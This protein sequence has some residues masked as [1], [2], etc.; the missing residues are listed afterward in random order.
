MN[1]IFLKTPL[2]QEK[3]ALLQVMQRVAR[4]LDLRYFVVGA[5]ARDILMYHFHGFPVNRASPDIDFALA[6]ESWDAFETVRDAL[7]QEQ[8]FGVDAKISQRLHYSP[9]AADGFPI[10]MIPFGGVEISPLAVAWPPDMKIVMNVAGYAEALDSVIEVSV[11]E[12]LIIP[13]AS[14]PG[15]LM[16][17]FIALLIA[18]ISMPKMPSTSVTSSK[19]MRTRGMSIGFMA[20]NFLYS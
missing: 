18:G 9:E 1:P 16:T 5:A 10:D 8:G 4:A 2:P 7:L 12:E 11:D 15:L 14:I 6:V 20:K 13:V 19:I 17:K 3:Q